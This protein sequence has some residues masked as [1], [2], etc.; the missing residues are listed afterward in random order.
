[1]DQKWDDEQIKKALRGRV[2]EGPSPEVS[3]RVW[4]SIERTLQERGADPSQSGWDDASLRGALKGRVP[5][6]VPE[7]VAERTWTAIEGA[8][9]DEGRN[10][11]VEGRGFLWE[12]TLRYAAAVLLFLAGIGSALEYRSYRQE[13]KVASYLETLLEGGQD[14]EEE[15]PVWVSALLTEPLDDGGAGIPSEDDDDELGIEEG[16]AWL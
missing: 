11:S 16:E 2:P 1:M 15:G 4:A 12:P 7:E 14:A 8:V 6:E 13:G 10:R 9:R 5:Q 3:Q